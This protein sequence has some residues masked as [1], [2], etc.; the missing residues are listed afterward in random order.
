MKTLW[1]TVV[2]LTLG[3]ISKAQITMSPLTT[4]C[5]KKC[6]GSVQFQNNSVVPVPFTV[7]AYNTTFDQAGP[8]YSPLLPSEHIVFDKNSGKLQPREI[9]EIDFKLMCDT[10]C[11]VTVFFIAGGSKTADGINMKFILTHQIYSGCAKPSN[12][13]TEV[14]TAAGLMP[15]K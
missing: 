3:S 7:E 4:S 14:L 6:S 11:G 12:C 2:M 1:I 9:R 13:R 10:T 5:G 15:K 8:H